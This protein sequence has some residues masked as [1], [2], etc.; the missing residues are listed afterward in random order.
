MNKL[1]FGTAGIPISTPKSSTVNGIARVKELGLECMELEFVRS[2]NISEQKVPLV[3][4]AAEKHNVQL[5]CHAP[6]YINLNSLE[7]KKIAE[8]KQRIL[9]S[10]RIAWLCGAKSLTFHAGFYMKK[11]AEEVYQQIR[12]GIKEIVQTLKKEGNNILIRPET[13][14]KAS[15]WGDWKEIIRLSQEVEQVLP[16]LDFSHAYARSVGEVNTK[17]H[18]RRILADIEKALGRTA[19]DNMHI[20]MSGIHYSE[21]GERWH[22]NLSQCQFNYQDLLKVWK[23]FR[24]KGVVISESPNIEED[25]LILKEYYRKI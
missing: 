10:A 24:I 5:T 4:A 22:L 1:Y 2:V 21:K 14:G 11:E 7:Q 18:F 23:E 17:E 6:Y 9:K 20:H 13:T 25:A 8:S 16:C 12:K 15:Q 3:R 19:L